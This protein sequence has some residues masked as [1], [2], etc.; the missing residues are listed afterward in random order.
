LDCVQNARPTALIGVTGVP[1]LFDETVI[2]TMASHHERP[3]IF[4]LSNPTSRA[5]ATPKDLIAWTGGRA[6]I[7][8]GSPFP[9]FDHQ[10]RAYRADQTNNAYIFPGVGLGVLATGARHVS[11]GMLL[12]AAKTLAA[13]SPSRAGRGGTLLPPISALRDVAVEIAT[14]VGAAAI[15]EGLAEPRAGDLKETIRARMWRPRY[16]TYRHIEG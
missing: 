9:A 8:V 10:G 15:E 13:L 14:A 6:I 3:V 7:G 2:R 4:P 5:E 12:A 16:L 11:D 1:G